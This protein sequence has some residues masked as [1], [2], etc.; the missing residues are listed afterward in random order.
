MDSISF[1]NQQ[2]KAINP[3][4]QALGPD[5]DRNLVAEGV[6]SLSLFELV[7]AIEERYHVQVTD[8]ILLKLKTFGSLW[9]LLEGLE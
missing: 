4:L 3:S 1:L 7:E 2:L 8:D 9:V 5:D 6:D